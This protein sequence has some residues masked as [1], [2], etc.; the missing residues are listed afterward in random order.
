MRAAASAPVKQA[1]DTNADVV[2]KGA[3]TRAA[4]PS[5][6][7]ARALAARPT[8]PVTA[9]NDSARNASQVYCL[10]S[11]RTSAI[12]MQ[13]TTTAT[14]IAASLAVPRLSHARPRARTYAAPVANI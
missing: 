5:H 10:R 7:T 2:L 1:T 13:L 9:S 6:T 11:F 14:A 12:G 8:S 3:A 4:T